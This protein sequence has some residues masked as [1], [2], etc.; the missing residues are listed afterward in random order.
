MIVMN[1]ISDRI[2]WLFVNILHYNIL[3]YTIL[4]Y[5]TL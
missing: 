4:Y 2:A 5:I 3:Y 1:V